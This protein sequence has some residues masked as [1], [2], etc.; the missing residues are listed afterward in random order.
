MPTG[1]QDANLVP[2]AGSYPCAEDYGRVIPSAEDY[3]MVI[4]SA[5]DYGRVIPSAI[6]CARVAPLHVLLRRGMTPTLE[7]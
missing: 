1:K 7:C 6:W 4:P 5:E 3:G 2:T